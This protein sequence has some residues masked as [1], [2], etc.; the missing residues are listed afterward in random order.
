[1][2][3]SFHE[4]M[5]CQGMG[6]RGGNTLVRGLFV[7]NQRV[8]GFPERGVILEGGTVTS[9]KVSRALIALIYCQ[10]RKKDHKD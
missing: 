4:R 5:S 3:P 2:C 8:S 10:T 6:D 9:G 1:M 7:S